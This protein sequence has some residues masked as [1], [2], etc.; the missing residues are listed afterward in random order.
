MQRWRTRLFSSGSAL[1]SARPPPLTARHGCTGGSRAD[2][3]V[4]FLRAL[5]MH[6]SER[7]L[8]ALLERDGELLR[9]ASAALW[10]GL[11]ALRS[12]GADDAV[13]VAAVLAQQHQ[14]DGRTL[15][16]GLVRAW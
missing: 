5:S 3:E 15:G 13:P 8:R 14:H 12:D 7:A 16:E 4:C 10:R 6:A 1:P 11:A 9:A 2:G